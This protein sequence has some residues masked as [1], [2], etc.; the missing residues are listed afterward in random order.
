MAGGEAAGGHGHPDHDQMQRSCRCQDSVGGLTMQVA[1]VRTTID[2]ATGRQIS[3]ELME[4]VAA[5][6]V[7]YIRKL[8]DKQKTA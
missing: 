5:R 3:E 7:D 1:I 6:G 4:M 2:R 8:L